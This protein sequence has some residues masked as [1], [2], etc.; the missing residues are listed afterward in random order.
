VRDLERA[1]GGRCVRGRFSR[2]MGGDE[3]R[4]G[5]RRGAWE[6]IEGQRHSVE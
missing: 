6:D 3:R 2:D 4:G 1:G 5:G